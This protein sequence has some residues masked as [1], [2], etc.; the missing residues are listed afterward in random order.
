MPVGDGLTRCPLCKESYCLQNG[1]ACPMAPKEHFEMPRKEGWKCPECGRIW[2]PDVEGCKSCNNTMKRARV[3]IPHEP[4]RIN[5]FR[6][7]VWEVVGKEEFMDHEYGLLLF[8]NMD[9]RDVVVHMRF[10]KTEEEREDYY[11]ELW[12]FTQMSKFTRKEILDEKV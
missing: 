12:Q 11:V 5:M 4:G 10:F 9:S 8:E 7:R 1:H 3:L 2:A 6:E